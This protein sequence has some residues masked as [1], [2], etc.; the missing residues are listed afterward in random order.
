MSKEVK[1]ELGRRVEAVL[2]PEY[3]ESTLRPLVPGPELDG[4]WDTNVLQ[5]DG[6]GAATI[7]IKHDGQKQIFA[8][9]YYDESGAVI[10]DKLRALR[11]AG[12]GA[13]ERYQAVEP[14]AFIPEYGM[15]L[16]RAADGVPVSA[17][18]EGDGSALVDGVRES[19][20]W[21]AKLHTSPVRVGKP[22]ALVAS[23]EVL[24]VGR[25]FA[26]ITSRRAD[27]YQ[28]GVEMI[29]TLE[30]MAEDVVEGLLVQSH[31]Q[32]RP[33][34]VFVSDAT[35]T[36]ID[37]DRTRPCDPARDIAEYLWRLRRLAFEEAGDA[38][39]ADAPTDA[40]LETYASAVG[41]GSYLTNLQFH[42]A[43]YAIHSINKQMKDLTENEEDRVD[44]EE[45]RARLEASLNFCQSEY[46]NVLE[47]R[48]SV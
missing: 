33:I 22:R 38:S 29:R 7:E 20:R 14:L 24:S 6:T 10:Y 43:R 35:V 40:F 3:L 12:L 5:L 44:D 42:L 23:S 36:V 13:G 9:L 32:Y 28:V 37:L 46:A 47:G 1:R 11:E 45:D 15:M 30:R 27:Y 18:I 17:Y 41:D 25:R 19:A 4:G 39:R 34:H 16:A 2:Q 31:G 48:F 8:K 26:K 21:L